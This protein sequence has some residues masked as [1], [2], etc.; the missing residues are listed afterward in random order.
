MTLFCLF[1]IYCLLYEP[2]M[3]AF[4]TVCVC[5]CVFIN[6]CA[7]SCFLLFWC[8]FHSFFW[9]IVILICLLSCFIIFLFL[10]ILWHIIE[11]AYFYNWTICAFVL[12]VNVLITQL[13]WTFAEKLAG[14]DRE[15]WCSCSFFSNSQ[16][17]RHRLNWY[18]YY[19]NF[20]IV[21]LETSLDSYSLQC[22]ICLRLCV[23]WKISG[24]KCIFPLFPVYSHLD[25][26]LHPL[27]HICM[28]VCMFVDRNNI[29]TLAMVLKRN[30]K[31]C[32]ILCVVS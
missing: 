25:Y 27:M 9:I 3:I 1:T 18:R 17:N 5:L 31:D 13:P 11:Y 30:C 21:V 29:I 22:L 16:I 4:Y 10:S 2:I 7:A 28:Y 23:Q 15:S 6:V 12:S 24:V 20:V 19:D 8:L 26:V 32:A 14:G